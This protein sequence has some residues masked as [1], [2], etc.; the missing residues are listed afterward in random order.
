MSKLN[1]THGPLNIGVFRTN[2]DKH[3]TIDEI[4]NMLLESVDKTVEHGDSI[5]DYYFVLSST[6][7]NDPV[8]TAITGNG[9]TSKENAILY[10][11]AP[12]MLDALI[13]EYKIFDGVYR[14][15]LLLLG[16]EIQPKFESAMRIKKEAIERATGKSIEEVL[17]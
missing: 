10:S 17:S 9:P 2:K 5:N 4:K 8:Y 14:M 13:E 15:G 12:E 1:H 3:P 16:S 7:K 11:A 6:D